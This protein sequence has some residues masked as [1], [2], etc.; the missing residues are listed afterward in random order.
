M[1]FN[2]VNKINIC[3]VLILLLAA[4][5]CKKFIEAPLPKDQIEA[6]AAFNTKPTIQASVNGLHSALGATSICGVILRTTYMISDEAVILPVPG[7]DVGDVITGNFNASLVTYAAFPLW[8]DYYKAINMANVLLENLPKV[9][10][11]VLTEKEKKQYTGAALFSRAYMHFLLVSGWGDV[12]LITS[13][14]AAENM[15]KP[16]T[17][18]DEVYAAVIS[19]LQEAMANLSTTVTDSR[20]IH[21]KYQ[22][23]ALLARVYLYLGKWAEAEAA[24]T[25]IISSGQYQIVSGLNNVFKRGSKESIFS[26]AE[27]ST[28]YLNLAYLG[29]LT[30]PFNIAQAQ[31]LY[32]HLTDELLNSFETGDQRVV[33]GNWTTTVYGLRFSYKYWYS[34]NDAAATISANP[35]D[36]VALRYAEQYLVRA[37]ARAQMGNISGATADLNV[38]RARAALGN[39]VA[40]DKAGVLTAVENERRHELFCEGHRWYDLVRTGRADAVLGAL[41]WKT[42]WKPACKLFPIYY[43][44]L[45]SNPNLVQNPGY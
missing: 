41:P 23:E 32:P 34:G 27:V 22:A 42:N 45:A 43:T 20:T 19:D 29:Y 39:V 11:S 2:T 35:Q 24:A 33:N 6:A 30:I 28:P 4:S 21:N 8:T 1:S 14:N 40:V 36:Y 15:V 16:R 7:A 37:E 38:I 44:E 9:P 10:A 31:T 3:G 12:P 18:K 5:S 17:P 26:I 13:T 25:D